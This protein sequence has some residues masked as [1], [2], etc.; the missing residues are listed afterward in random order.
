MSRIVLENVT[1]KYG[2]TLALSGVSMLID[3]SAFVVV[4]GPSGC[5]KTT[6]LRCIAGLETPE[7]GHI[8]VDGAVIDDLSPRERDLSMVFQNY[9]L[10]THMTV[11]R[12]IAFPLKVRNRP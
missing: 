6:L 5:G 12:N 1:K 11:E 7:S 10:F 4:L 8:Y 9:A 3:D 2:E